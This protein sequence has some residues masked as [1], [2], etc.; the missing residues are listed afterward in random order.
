MTEK[1]TLSPILDVNFKVY[2]KAHDSWS[3]SFLSS[4]ILHMDVGV[5]VQHDKGEFP[6]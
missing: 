4:V 2:L 1:S 6:P 3:C 5:Q